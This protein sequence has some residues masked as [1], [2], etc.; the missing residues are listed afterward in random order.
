MEDHIIQ[1]SIEHTHTQLC[2]CVSMTVSVKASFEN[3]PATKTKIVGK[4]EGFS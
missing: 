2:T 1:I 3:F 4:T